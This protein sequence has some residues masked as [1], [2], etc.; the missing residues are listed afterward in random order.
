M[1]KP[2]DQAFK[3]LTEEDPRATLALF[4]GIPLTVAIDVCVLDREVNLPALQVDNLYRCRTADAEFLVHI[5][6]VT[7]FRTAVLDR[8]FDYVQAIVAKYR[9][10]CRSYLVLLTEKSVPKVLPRTMRRVHGD[11]EATL[12][13]RAVRLWRIPAARILRL[14]SVQLLPWVPLLRASAEEME[15]AMR[16]LDI[17][18]ENVLRTRLFLLGGLRYGSKEAFLERLNQMIISEEILKESSTYQ[19]LIEKGVAKGRRE[20]LVRLLTR[21]FG[22]LPAATQRKL[23]A[24][25][26]EKLD[27]WFDQA[28]DAG[29]LKDA[30]K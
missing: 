14:E 3:L 20:D 11:Y 9:M 28:L 19:Y 23:D 15:E 8:Q 27:R 4:A 10:A 12:R 26:I 18:D 13:L 21:R 24:A 29:S 25:P 16:R 22:P 6:A 2:Y 7:R 17:A 5:E 1:A 30:L